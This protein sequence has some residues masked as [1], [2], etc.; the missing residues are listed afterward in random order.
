MI[1][2]SIGSDMFVFGQSCPEH[3]TCLS[4][5]RTIDHL[6]LLKLNSSIPNWYELC[7]CDSFCH[8]FGDCCT[9]APVLDQIQLDEWSFV[10]VRLSSKISFM[11]LMK[12]KCP[13]HWKQP[14][15]EVK[16]KCELTSLSPMY[17]YL[18][19]DVEH[20]LLF[21]IEDEFN[22]WHVTGHD[23][24]ITYRNL[25][26]S[27]CNEDS[28]VEA[29]NQRLRCLPIVDKQSDASNK[30]T[31]VYYQT[32]PD[33]LG[34][35]KLKRTPLQ[36]KVYSTCNLGW[37]KLNVARQRDYVL[38][39]VKKC[40]LFYK[41]VV[42]QDIKS[43]KFI[44]FKNKYC[45]QCNEYHQPSHQCPSEAIDQLTQI[46]SSFNVITN[47]DTNYINGS[48]IPESNQ[49]C[50][51]GQVFNPLI[52]LCQVANQRMEPNTRIKQMSDSLDH[53]SK[54]K[55]N[56]S[57]SVPQ[58]CLLLTYLICLLLFTLLTTKT[59]C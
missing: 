33:L 11:S 34:K 57:S 52:R 55:I 44:V 20:L 24:L 25:Y 50:P 14:N 39:T 6:Q 36:N 42:V 19:P 12:S 1:L 28:Q 59:Y 53:S 21:D 37:Y 32:P 31:N 43:K 18:L 17:E 4:R 49:F 27:I 40:L 30:C 47:Y 10:K 16:S 51:A 56:S 48:A 41:P 23:S 13:P 5:D 26:C 8:I 58:N 3:F 46:P 7:N 15:S 9:D 29:W 2:F 38:N 22:N 35:E 45:A 54:E